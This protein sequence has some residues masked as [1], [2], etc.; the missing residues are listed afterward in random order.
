MKAILVIVYVYLLIM[1]LKIFN[2]YDFL[3]FISA[4]SS[5]Q[6]KLKND[7]RNIPTYM[8]VVIWGG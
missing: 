2:L 4:S 1:W 7:A 3:N 5:L 8:H 6:I